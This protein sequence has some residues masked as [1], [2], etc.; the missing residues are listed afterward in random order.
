MG[1]HDIIYKELFSDKD[2]VSDLLRGF[3]SPETVKNISFDTLR[4]PNSSYTSDKLKTRSD[5]IVWKV[6]YGD[7]WFFL[8]LLFEF[9]STSDN[10]MPVRM[11]SYVSL[12][13]EDLIKSKEVSVAHGKK[14]PPILPILIYDG[15]ENWVL[16]QTLKI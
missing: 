1:E 15:S 11:L 10:S 6:K 13:Y 16:P 2:I 5:D 12:L 3:L 7:N 4:K 9:Q 8:Y 14:L